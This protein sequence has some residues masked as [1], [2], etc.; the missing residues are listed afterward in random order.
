MT[1]SASIV[2]DG[3]DKTDLAYDLI[4]H[5]IAQ[6]LSGGSAAN[7]V[8]G[9]T[10]AQS[11]TQPTDKICLFPG[12]LPDEPPDAGMVSVNER[13]RLGSQPFREADATVVLR[14]KDD[15]EGTGFS[16]RQ[17]VHAAANAIERHLAPNGHERTLETLASGRR[18]LIFENVVRN[19][20][21]RDGSGRA[22]ATVEFTMKIS[23]AYAA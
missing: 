6:I 4:K 2:P 23:E 21:G 3:T 12:F 19:Y 20:G 1:T 22:L 18:V 7:F 13:A 11:E 16:G 8:D 14:C 5:F 17:K 15:A 9:A 10:P